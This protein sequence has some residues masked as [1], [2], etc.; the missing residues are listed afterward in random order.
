MKYLKLYENFT[1]QT[2]LERQFSEV[3]VGGL[4]NN[5]REIVTF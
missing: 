3:V 2:P 5:D 1:S 4:N